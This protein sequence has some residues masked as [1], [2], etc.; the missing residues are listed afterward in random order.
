MAGAIQYEAGL[1]TSFQTL[2]S[3][4]NTF[5]YFHF[6]F[7][8]Q[9]KK[10]KEMEEPILICGITI[11]KSK[12]CS[13][14]AL[15]VLSENMSAGFCVENSG[16]FFLV[17]EC[18]TNEFS[19]LLGVAN[20]IFPKTDSSIVFS[21]DDVDTKMF[22]E[23]RVLKEESED[24]QVVEESGAETEANIC[25]VAKDIY[26]RVLNISKSKSNLKDLKSSK[27]SLFLSS[28]DMISISKMSGFFGLEDMVKFMSTPIHTTL[29]S[30]QS[31]PAFE[32]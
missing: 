10:I 17:F 31:W 26:S 5:F 13:S 27:P 2:L 25:D 16:G 28:E 32:K 1:Y 18:D 15:K 20:K 24:D 7:V 23:F 8:F 9:H 22:S 4:K 12:N 14:D 19:R 30:D 21:I 29:P 6:R 3:K 11:R